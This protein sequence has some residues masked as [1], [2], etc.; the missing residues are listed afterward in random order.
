MDEN[1]NYPFEAEY[2][3]KKKSGEKQWQKVTVVDN[4]TD[5][6]NFEGG[7]FFVEIE[8]NEMLIS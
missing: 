5:D 8:L 4:E 1:I 2:L 7:V 6:S 3:A